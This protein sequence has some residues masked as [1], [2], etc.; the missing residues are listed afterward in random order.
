[1]DIAAFRAIV[2]GYVQGVGFRY[3][4][5][6]EAGRLGVEGWVRNLPDGDVEVWAEG[7]RD[8]VAAFRE[9]LAEGPPGARVDSVHAESR[10]PTGARGG[11]SAES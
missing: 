9:W 11:F 7:P 3:S 1:M 6:R 5:C 4:A 8:A 10:S 2:T